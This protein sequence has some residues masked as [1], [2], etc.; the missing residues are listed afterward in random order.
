MK[1]YSQSFPGRKNNVVDALLQDFDHSDVALTQILH[2]TCPLQLP[3]RFQI[4]P[5]PNKISSWLTSLQQKLPVKEQLREAHT[6]TTLGC[7]TV[8]P[9]TLNPSELV[10]TS[11]STPSQ[12]PNETRSSK[13]LPWLSGRGNFWD[14]LMT[15]WLWAQ[16]EIP[17]WIYARPSGRMA[18]PTQPRTMTSNLASFYTDSSEPSKTP[19]QKKSSKKPFPPAS[20]PRLQNGI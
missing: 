3:Q 16:F 8:S 14:H 20:L 5:L 6:R 12:D 1:E 19:T 11:S 4:A 7:G 13:P 2:D 18:D 10:T 9:D 17:S 15:P